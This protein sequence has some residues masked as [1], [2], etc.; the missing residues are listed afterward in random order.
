MNVSLDWISDYVDLTGLDVADIAHRITMGCAEVERIHRVARMV[1]GIYAAEVLSVSGIS[2]HD[3]LKYVRVACGATRFG[4][5]STAPNVRVGL[6]SLLAPAG[7]TVAGQKTVEK[8]R[9]GNVTSE[10]IL[11]SA[12]ELAFS[13]LQEQVIELPPDVESG[14]A[15]ADLVPRVD[16]VLEIDN[17]SLTHRPD[18]FGHYGVAREIAAIFHRSLCPLDLANLCEY[19]HLPRHSVR[20]EDRDA[21]PYYCCMR[22]RKMPTCP[23]P[24]HMQARL[25][26]V[27][28][29][30]INL[31]VDLS[32]YIMFEIGQ[33]TH[34]FDADKVPEIVVKRMGGP[35][36]LV[37]LDGIERTIA[38]ED[39]MIWN[40]NGPVAVAG[41]MGGASTQVGPDTDETLLESASFAGSAVRRTANRLGLRTE[42]SLRF[43]KNQP[44]S[45]APLGAARFLSLARA[46]GAKPEVLSQLSFDSCFGRAP[47][48]ILVPV[49]F[50]K[51]KLGMH[52]ATDAIVGILS[53]LGFETRVEE[54]AILTQTPSHRSVFDVSIPEDIVEEVARVYGYDNITPSLPV[55]SCASAPRNEQVDR[56]HACRKVLSEYHGYVEI[57]T[58]AWFDKDWIGQIGFAPDH[59][60]ELRNPSAES[61]SLLRTVLLPNVL[62]SAS[63]NAPWRDYFALYEIGRVFAAVS[64][65]DN[66]EH[67]HIAGVSVRREK[68]SDDQRHF[69]DVKGAVQNLLAAAHAEDPTFTQAGLIT[70]PWEKQDG[71]AAI[72]YGGREVGRMG[73]LPTAVTRPIGK[74]RGAVW[75]ELNLDQIG[76]A[77]TDAPLFSPISMYPSSFLDFSILW[78]SDATYGELERLIRR[79]E[80][81]RLTDWEFRYVYSDTELTQGMCSY[82][83]RCRLG[84]HERTLAPDDL[85]AVQKRFVCFADT[86][87][88]QIR[89]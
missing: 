74:H 62:Q 14:T 22:F 87:G 16:H 70:Q 58:Y 63:R 21:C 60:L 47:A 19:D 68:D 8:R 88:L 79:F 69:C 45:L 1:D 29:R 25:H 10:G 44:P 48:E 71:C 5:V 30:S 65:V 59:Y 43:E 73:V 17:K 15:L 66:S 32:N 27:G 18:L 20:V 36:A 75:F 2:A 33:P 6:K 42:A 82:T 57:H 26:A 67:T 72:R 46:A 11:C 4:V 41:V 9:F 37:T 39:L 34:V 86:Q 23:A 89:T 3:Q 49:E 81:P 12:R 31:L 64:D 78:P 84:L 76:P 40:G 77:Q 28:Q 51:R 7:C 56:I 24:L 80:D 83:F 52:I 13:D 50:V 55:I 85:D 53:R 35:G 61:L 38:S 54:G